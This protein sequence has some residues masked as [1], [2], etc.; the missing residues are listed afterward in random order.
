MARW[1][2]GLGCEEDE[3]G[4]A[5]SKE[6]EEEESRVAEEEGVG[7]CEE[8]EV[9]ARRTAASCVDKQKVIASSR[10]PKFL[11][12]HHHRRKTTKKK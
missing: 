8:G 12:Y 4:L 3:D 5:V 10:S 9:E 11:S 6:E 2:T 1:K 7:N